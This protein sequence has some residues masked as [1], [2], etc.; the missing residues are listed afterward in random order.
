[1]YSM[2]SAIEHVSIN[3][4]LA[5]L[6]HWSSIHFLDVH[7][8]NVRE[9]LGDPAETSMLSKNFQLSAWTVPT[10]KKVGQAKGNGLAGRKRR[11]G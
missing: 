7:S 2:Q 10:V 11:S 3:A 8:S 4:V 5:P 9:H 1:M 6:A